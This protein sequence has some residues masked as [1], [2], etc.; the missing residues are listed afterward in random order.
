MISHTTF[1]KDNIT[2]ITI[3]IRLY[4]LINFIYGF[5]TR[6]HIDTYLLRKEIKKGEEQIKQKKTDVMDRRQRSLRKRNIPSSISVRQQAG[7]P[8]A[9]P[10]PAKDCLAVVSFPVAKDEDDW[11]ADL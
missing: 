1:F 9:L 6:L 10:P 11:R 5:Y 7:P 8:L 4:L 3:H 2:S